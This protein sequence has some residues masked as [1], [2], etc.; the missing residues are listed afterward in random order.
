MSKYFVCFYAS[1]GA[2]L[3]VHLFAFCYSFFFF[4]NAWWNLIL[5][6]VLLER[7]VDDTWAVF[8]GLETLFFVDHDVVRVDADKIQLILCMHCKLNCQ[9]INL[10]PKLNVLREKNWPLAIFAGLETKSFFQWLYAAYE[11]K[12]Q[13]KI[14]NCFFFA[15]I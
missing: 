13:C 5:K 3:D 15:Q 9:K 4:C 2:A 11:F 14:Q 10:W 8:S 6:N 12:R 1:Y 7:C